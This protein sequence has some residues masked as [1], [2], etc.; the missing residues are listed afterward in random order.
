MPQQEIKTREVT[1]YLRPA[2]SIKFQQ[3]IADK[4]M[5]KSEALNEAVKLLLIKNGYAI[6]K[7][8]SKNQY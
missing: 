8:V 5:G 7:P 3:F 6:E 4:E 1:G 2:I